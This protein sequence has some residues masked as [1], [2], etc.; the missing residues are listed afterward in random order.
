M[1]RTVMSS[2]AR[3][4][5]KNAPKRCSAQPPANCSS[6]RSSRSHGFRSTF[7]ASS[8][9]SISGTAPQRKLPLESSALARNSC[10]ASAGPSRRQLARAWSG[11][12]SAS[13]STEPI[14]SGHSWSRRVAS[15][16][17]S[18]GD[19]GCRSRVR[20]FSPRSRRSVAS[21]TSVPASTSCPE[22]D[23]G[24]WRRRP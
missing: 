5:V 7:A 16:T 14:S 1:P 21:P 19:A 18:Q 15:S 3:V 22:P 12:S 2:V 24:T 20:R 17:S 4:P 10:Q 9:A 13:S 6:T 8:R 23:S 11:S